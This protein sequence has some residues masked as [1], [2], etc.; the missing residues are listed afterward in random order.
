MDGFFSKP[1]RIGE[2]IEGVEGSSRA[3]GTECSTLSP[4]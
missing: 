2:L 1:I 4:P 3:E